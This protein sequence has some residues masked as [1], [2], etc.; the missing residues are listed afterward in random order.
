MPRRTTAALT[1]PVRK[2]LRIAKK[3]SAPTPVIT[4][5]SAGMKKP[6]RPKKGGVPADKAIIA[7]VNAVD[8]GEKIGSD[9]NINPI[10]AIGATPS[11]LDA[12]A[13]AQ[14]G[15]NTKTAT[16]RKPKK[17]SASVAKKRGRPAGSKTKKPRAANIKKRGR[18]A[19]SKTKKAGAATMA[20]LNDTAKEENI[21]SLPPMEST[22]TIDAVGE[23]D[24]VAT[25]NNF[26]ADIKKCGGL[27]AAKAGKPATNA[28]ED[29]YIT[30][31]IDEQ[32]N[33]KKMAA[34]EANAEVASSS[35]NTASESRSLT[36]EITATTTTAAAAAAAAA[37]RSRRT[38]APDALAPA[39]GGVKKR[40]RPAKSKKTGADIM[41]ALSEATNK[42][43]AASPTTMESNGTVDAMVKNGDGA[44][45]S[46]AT[47]SNS[48]P[49]IK[50]GNGFAKKSAAKVGKPA[51]K[52]KKKKKNKK[53]KITDAVD[54]PDNGKKMASPVANTCDDSSTTTPE[55]TAT[56]AAAK[57]RLQP[58]S[59]QCTASGTQT[60]PQLTYLQGITAHVCCGSPSLRRD[61]V[62]LDNRHLCWMADGVLSP[63]GAKN[64]LDN[65]MA[66][67]FAKRAAQY[68]APSAPPE[69]LT[70]TSLAHIARAVTQAKRHDREAWLAKHCTP[71]GYYRAKSPKALA[72]RFSQLRLNKAPTAPYLHRTNR[73]Q[74]DKCWF[75]PG[76]PIQ[77]RERLFK[78]CAHWRKGQAVLWKAVA[79]ATKEEKESRRMNTPIKVLLSDERCTEA[80][81]AFLGSTHVGKWPHRG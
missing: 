44:A 46:A 4:P 21:A 28:K 79:D 68:Q 63:E 3:A 69:V 70:T 51:T 50:K 65:E 29:L 22:N 59:P 43:I 38:K 47:K 14:E 41:A 60:R 48:S 55:E 32:D 42:E 72:S 66:D 10:D 56:A 75:C 64:I 9:G 30:I 36:P 19:T 12:V 40:G 1:A 81:L 6:G 16:I 17:V 27:P 54:E 77:T 58:P 80:V 78:F 20:A 39:F 37:T 74:D 26:S 8:D 61:I 35:N 34:P 62:A 31:A 24:A 76:R 33:G 45:Q 23:P 71:K 52:A 15:D 49:D 11:A 5:V 67:R 2:S 53:K 13:A 73:R 7:A 25:T 18:A 57:Q